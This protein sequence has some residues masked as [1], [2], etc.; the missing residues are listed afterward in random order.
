M[1]IAAAMSMRP[2]AAID[3]PAPAGVY[4]AQ[5]FAA[6]GPPTRRDHFHGL[7]MRHRRPAERR[8]VDP[9]QR[10]DADRGG[11]GG[12]LSVLH[13]RAERRRRGRARPAPGEAGRPSPARRRSSRRGSPSSTSPAS[14]AA[15][16]RARASATSSWPTSAKCDAIAHVVRCFEDGDITHVEG[17]I[18]P[19]ADIETIETELMLADLESLEKRVVAAREEGQGRRQ[20]SQGAG[21]P[22]E[23]LPRRCCARASP[24]ASSSVTPR[25][26]AALLR[27]LS[28]LTSKPVLYVCNVEE[29]CGRQG[30]RLLRRRS[31]SAREAKKAPSR[32]WSRPRSRA[33]SPCSPPDEQKEYLEAVGLDEPGLN[34]VIRAGYALL[35]LRDLLHRRARRRRAP[36]RSSKGT[37]APQAAGVIHTDFEKGFIRAETIAYD[38]YVASRAKPARA[39][40]A[41]SASKARTTSCRTATCCTSASRTEF[42]CAVAERTS[43]RRRPASTTG[44]AH[45]HIHHEPLPRTPKAMRGP[46]GE[47]RFQTPVVDPGL[48]RDDDDGAQCARRGGAV[49]PAKAG[50]HGRP[51][52]LPSPHEPLARR[53]RP[54]ERERAAT[55]AHTC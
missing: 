25:S 13:H 2:G 40:P 29:A 6:P 32:W 51:R 36:G 14:C 52:V 38:D 10:A 31:P 19:I 11:A 3:R 28:L 33:R 17:K 55:S 46:C 7:Q 12:E 53:T 49:M 21:R 37:R 23:P 48:R 54:G 27:M 44:H 43:C 15:R 1:A 39:R 34:R 42:D 41:S 35:D 4:A 8:Q 18:D 16:P 24:R 9:L 50:I 5:G 45:R 22:R 47:C 26:D 30:Q 20:G